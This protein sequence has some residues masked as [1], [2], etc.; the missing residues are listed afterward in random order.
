MEKDIQNHNNDE[1]EIDL[2]E[3]FGELKKNWKL[4]AGTTVAFA[5][6]AAIYSFCIA[7]PVYQYNAMIRIP[8]NIINHEFTVNTCLE[9]L[10]ND[11]VASVKN[12]RRT[13]LLSL[14]F[15]AYS[16]ADAKAVAEAYLPKA[17]EKVNRIIKGADV[18]VVDKDVVGSNKETVMPVKDAKAELILQNKQLDVPVSPNKKKNIAVAALLGLFMS[19]G[20]IIG[21]FLWKK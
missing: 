11:G 3:L 5:A 19:C 14:S 10:K 13:S 12:A 16:P 17:L 21:K 7:K 8:A 18:V 1:I 20:Y 2:V 9:L 4:I 6:A 15:D